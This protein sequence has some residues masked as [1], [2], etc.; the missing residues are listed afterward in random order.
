METKPGTKETRSDTRCTSTHAPDARCHV[1]RTHPQRATSTNSSTC[2]VRVR[3]PP[4][5][6]VLLVR[7]DTR[8]STVRLPSLRLRRTPSS[9]P[10]MDV[11]SF[12]ECL[13]TCT[14]PSS[15][16]SAPSTC[17]TASKDA[18][19]V[20]TTAGRTCGSVNLRVYHTSL[21]RTSDDRMVRRKFTNEFTASR[22][23]VVF[24]A[25]FCA[26]NVRTRAWHGVWDP[27]C[28]SSSSWNHAERV[29]EDVRDASVRK[30]DA[31]GHHGAVARAPARK[32]WLTHASNASKTSHDGAGRRA[33]ATEAAWS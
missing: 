6:R 7:W 12:H 1:V 19:F 13:P 26:S 31:R 29:R 30:V 4:S 10:Q 2:I 22:R 28:A 16:R 14:S 18:R 8:S 3:S 21:S 32:R 27:S 17:E 20:A 5:L 33:D 15:R 25:S 11:R 23:H 24:D 9:R